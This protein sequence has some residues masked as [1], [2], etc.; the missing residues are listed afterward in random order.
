[1]PR[2]IVRPQ[3]Y[4][5]VAECE[6]ARALRDVLDFVH[7]HQ[8]LHSDV[9]HE[10]KEARDVLGG[11]QLDPLEKKILEDFAHYHVGVA[12]DWYGRQ[13]D[14]T[15]E[16]RAEDGSGVRRFTGEVLGFQSCP[17]ERRVKLVAVSVDPEVVQERS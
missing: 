6:I 4:E 15:V 2:F 7:Y 8:M 17:D 12:T 13:R 5:D 9:E 16:L 10:R 14:L 11:W 3:G 1:M